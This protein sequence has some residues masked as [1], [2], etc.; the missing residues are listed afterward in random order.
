MSRESRCGELR[1]VRD[2][3]APLHTSYQQSSWAVPTRSE[4]RHR[5][6]R[7]TGRKP[8][9]R[10]LRHG[11]SE[12]SRVDVSHQ[13]SCPTSRRLRASLT[14]ISYR[15]EADHHAKTTEGTQR[16]SIIEQQQIEAVHERGNHASLPRSC[17][18][19]AGH[20]AR[21]QQSSMQNARGG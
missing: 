13:E 17:A 15:E 14:L 6:A 8:A 18:G 10:T 7:K 11:V 21:F 4:Q 9:T 20:H 3:F 1:V 2:V 16:N 5:P 12:A 19:S